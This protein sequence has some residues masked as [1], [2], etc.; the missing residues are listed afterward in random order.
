LFVFVI[1]VVVGESQ[2]PRVVSVSVIVVFVF[3]KLLAKTIEL[4]LTFEYVTENEL[5][6]F[7]EETSA[8]DPGVTV[9]LDGR[10]RQS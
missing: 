9:E 5:L 2:D 6:L 3:R 7:F 8:S 10:T 4:I 1:D